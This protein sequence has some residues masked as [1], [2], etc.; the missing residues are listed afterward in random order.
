MALGINETLQSQTFKSKHLVYKEGVYVKYPGKDKEILACILPALSDP[1]DKSQYA[2]CR[3]SDG[4]KDFSKWAVGL[5]MHQ[6]VGKE[7]N[8]ISPQTNDPEAFDPIDE[9]IRVARMDP[10]YCMIAGY[11]SDGKRLVNAYKNPDVKLSPRWNG[12]VVNAI[13]LND[14]EQDKSKPVILQV[15]GTAFARGG[16]SGNDGSQSWGLLSELYR[17]NRS[18]NGEPSDYYW[19]DITDPRAM[20][21]C[22][23]KLTPSPAGGISIYNMVPQPDEPS[24]RASIEMLKGRYDLDKIFYDITE[25]EIIDRLIFYFK[26]VPKLLKRAFA[27]RVPNFDRLLTRATAAVSVPAAEDEEEGEE[28][29]E[30]FAPKPAR[31]REEPEDRGG[32]SPDNSRSFAPEEDDLPPPTARKS[33]RPVSEDDGEDEGEEREISVPTRKVSA[34]RKVSVKDLLD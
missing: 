20:V 4:P 29:I 1:K 25:G 19:G 34:G 28:E 12:Y 17:K 24:V 33:A 22:S 8:I 32:D 27:H 23:L 6:F 18:S 11:G 26:D 2:P 13:I 9:L 16:K 14:R 7:Q 31:R 15:P 10:D 30:A 21:P 5:K 3:N